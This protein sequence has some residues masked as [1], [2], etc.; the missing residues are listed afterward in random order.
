[1]RP[2]VWEADFYRRPLQTER[3]EPLWEL[4][5]CDT[6]GTFRHRASCPQSAAT[7]EWLLAEFNQLATHQALPDRLR[8]FRPQTLNLLEAIAPDLGIVVEPSRRTPLVKS[9]LQTLAR[10]YPT[11]PN[12]VPQPYDPVALEKPPPLPLAENLWGDRWRF[13]A[14]A[15]GELVEAF[16][17]RMMPILEMPEDL[18]PLH[19]GLASTAPIPGV[20]IDGGRQSMRLAR[21]LQQIHPVALSYIPGAPDGLILEAGLIDRWVVATFEDQEVAA[22]A[23]GFQQRQMA[24]Q[25]LHF[26]LVQPDDSG[27]TFSGFWL[28]QNLD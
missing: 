14:L 19:L 5:L 13:A 18:K 21:W 8:V 28:L 20:V 23:H 24:S 6:R 7:T 10:E 16:E 4:V 25:G 3:A 9:W 2:V 17:G 27:M 12:Y 1:M 15:A 22:A 11:L 26:L